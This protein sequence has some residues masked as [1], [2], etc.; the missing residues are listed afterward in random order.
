MGDTAHASAQ[1]DLVAA[2]GPLAL[3]AL[4]GEPLSTLDTRT[5]SGFTL[6]PLFA[7]A[8]PARLGRPGSGPWQVVQRV[9][10]PDSATQA[11][12]DL[13]NGASALALVFAGAAGAH[14]RGLPVAT[15]D[16][17]DAAL[18]GVMLDLVPVHLEAGARGLAAFALFCA[19]VERRGTKAAALH[20]GLD[21]VGTFVA[22]GARP[23]FAAPAALADAVRAFIGLG[24]AGTVFRA[25]GRVV[26]EAGAS[27]ATELAFALHSVARLLR[28]LDSAGVAPDT[29][30]PRI[31]MAL[32]ANED[33]FATIAKFR[34]AR[35][36]HALLA[37]ACGVAGPLTL[38]AETPLRMIAFCDP[39]TNLL[40]LT[41]AAFSAGVGGAD[42]VAVLPF[43]AAGSS[44]ARRMSRNIQTLLIEEA[45]VGRLDDPGAGSGAVEACTDALAQA[46]W[47]RFQDMERDEDYV[48]SGRLAENVAAEAADAARQLADGDR[49]IV[50]V[51]I[52]RPARS[53]DI[54]TGDPS[55]PPDGRALTPPGATF[56]DLRSAA[57]DGATLAD[58]QAAG[59]GEPL[60]CPPL[61]PSRA[62]AAFGG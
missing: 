55:P 6:G 41:L 57:R 5:P 42:S 53:A 7:P 54:P 11:R 56:V 48:T 12:E 23:G 43:D 62:A 17:L 27:P 20:A 26:A 16:D 21:P 31:A 49:A 40:R 24:I 10:G 60:A 51:T 4:R 28:R 50:G 38:H 13:E 59:A 46:A 32:A 45:H 61:R 35:R 25:D 8:P 37:G 29:A 58:L 2:W 33:Q 30:L 44:L 52:H 3:T 19:L 47:S 39:H 1:A 36:L 15:V 18:A 22:S 9:D 14:G 34:A